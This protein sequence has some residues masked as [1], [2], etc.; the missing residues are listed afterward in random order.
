MSQ[1]DII[2]VTYNS[3]GVI[4]PC[5]QSLPAAFPDQPLH[6]F[7]IDNNSTDPTETIVKLWN[8][9][10][11]DNVQL[12]FM[13]NSRNTGFTKAVNQGLQQSQAPFVL[14]LNPDTI[15]PESALQTLT[16]FFQTEEKTGVIAPQLRNN[17]G[18]IQ[19]SCRRLPW[20]RDVFF[21]FLGLHLLF[22]ESALFNGWKMG[23]FDHKT[24]RFV[25][26]PQGAFLLMKKA[27]LQK[28][29]LL[30]ENFPMFF[31]DVDWCH[32]V[33]LAGY[34]IR[35]SPEVAVLHHQGKSVHS[36]RAHMI[37]S[38]HRSF[39]AYFY[40]YNRGIKWII[41]NIFTTLLLIITGLLRFLGAQILTFTK[42]GS[43]PNAN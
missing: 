39:I 35:F 33:L 19:P 31:S 26:Q 24:A 10:K 18:S 28:V 32:R 27:V 11:P 5:L 8:E 23:D 22:P 36:R 38:S 37:L 43:A 17:D 2:I 4:L 9:S 20:H 6:I 21:H 25:D 30:D 12:T 13:A 29:G 42:K 15:L 40:K 34:A 3:S 1:L 41:P 16:G 14:L 7:V